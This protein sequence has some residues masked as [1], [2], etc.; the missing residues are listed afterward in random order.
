MLNLGSRNV[1]IN[2]TPEVIPLLTGS[3]STK[4]NKMTYPSGNKTYPVIIP[5]S[6]FDNFGLSPTIYSM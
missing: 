5:C 6:V 3:K 2:G 1:W 4:I